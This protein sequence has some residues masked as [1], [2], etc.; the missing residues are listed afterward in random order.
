MFFLKGYLLI[1]Y[2]LDMKMALNKFPA[3]LLPAFLKIQK[4]SN[5]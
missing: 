5:N 1:C 2:F 4:V 3:F